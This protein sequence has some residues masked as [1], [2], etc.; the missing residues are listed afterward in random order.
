MPVPIARSDE[1]Y[2]A[3]L[4]DLAFSNE[5]FLGV[6]HAADGVE[7]T[8]KRMAAAAKYAPKFGI[9]CECGIARARKT[10]L[11]RRLLE[12]HAAASA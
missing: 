4:K 5:L 2:F 9:A 6:V 10:G 7:G 8:R 11:V 1:A 12:I 3:P